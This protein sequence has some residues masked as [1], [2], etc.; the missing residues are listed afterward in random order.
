MNCVNSSMPDL[1]I[2]HTFP[3]SGKPIIKLT[4]DTLN[5][6]FSFIV[7]L[8]D[9]KSVASVSTAWNTMFTEIPRL[10]KRL[11]LLK[12]NIN[13]QM[14]FECIKG[15]KVTGEKIDK[16]FSILPDNI[17]EILNPTFLLT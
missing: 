8:N 4:S 11:K 7:S 14:W 17:C 6:I 10:G 13:I 5:H 9:L 2:T 16:A 15:A 3:A 1:P 12:N